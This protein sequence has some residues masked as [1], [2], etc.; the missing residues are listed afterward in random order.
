[1][2]NDMANN[3]IRKAA[4]ALAMLAATAAVRAQVDYSVVAVNE[5]SGLE[6]T[7]ITQDND[8]VCMPEVRR[9][10][11]TVNWFSN[12]IIDVSVDGRKLAYISARGETTNIFIKDVARQGGS[13]QRTNRRAVIDFSYSP[14]GSSICFSEQ[15]GDHNQI[16][17]TA[18]EG[19]YVCR[20]ITSGSADF[21]PV[22]SADM[23]NIFFARQENSGVSV[24]SYNV[25]NNFLA[26]YTRG[27]NPCPIAGR[28]AMLCARTD[29]SGRGEIWRVD[30]ETGVEECL[31]A[32]PNRSFTTPSMS[33]DGR[34][35]LAV[36]SNVLMNGTQRYANTDIFVC[37]A[38]GTGL[39]QL[40]YHAADDL[41]PAWSRDGKYIYFISQ[42]GSATAT[43][44]VW[45][46]TF[47]Y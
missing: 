35:I 16:F 46:M 32:D 21:T 31:M 29:A 38:D 25:A 34:W 5:E 1:M 30:Y 7:R 44:N 4:L 24:W 28:K 6:L 3:D 37:R 20:Q 11:G 41:S 17:Q 23:K 40:T 36:G 42:R 18:A 9:M 27:M 14:D 12:R 10:G 13:V 47:A 45:R 2:T 26:S 22:Y 19:S 39:T 43:A 15:N 8:F 33:P